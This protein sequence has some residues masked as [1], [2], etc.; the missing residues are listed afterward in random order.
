MTKVLLDKDFFMQDL[1]SEELASAVIE[2]GPIDPAKMPG[3]RELGSRDAPP[4]QFVSPVRK[5]LLTGYQWERVRQGYRNGFY[6][7]AKVLYRQCCLICTMYR[8]IAQDSEE[9]LR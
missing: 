8:A 4:E 3:R 6:G 2:L 7:R 9:I 1:T 5:E